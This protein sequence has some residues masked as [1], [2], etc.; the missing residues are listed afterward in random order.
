VVRLEGCFRVKA[1][2]ATFRNGFSLTHGLDPNLIESVSGYNHTDNIITAD[3]KGLE[4]GHRLG[5]NI[6]VF[7]YTFNNIPAPSSGLF[8]NTERNNPIVTGEMIEVIITFNKPTDPALMG[9]APFN[10]SILINGARGR[11][12]HLAGKTSKDLANTSYFN[13]GHDGSDPANIHYYRTENN[14]HWGI[15]I[16]H[17]FRYPVEKVPI[18]NAKNPLFIR[19]LR[20]NFTSN[21]G[22]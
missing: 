12:L 6:I 4:A 15:N 10:P 19:G 16:I 17:E 11:E 14:H 5:A 9:S 20:P 21:S 18:N 3:A 7:D 2:G 13:T 22:L 8:I 1:I